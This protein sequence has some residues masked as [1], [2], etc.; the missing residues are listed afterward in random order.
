MGKQ[1]A[2]KSD[3]IYSNSPPIFTNWA[4]CQ[5][6]PGV[7]GDIG[8]IPRLVG[9]GFFQVQYTGTL[10]EVCPGES[11]VMLLNPIPP[12]PAPSTALQTFSLYTIPAGMVGNGEEWEFS[13]QV[14]AQANAGSDYVAISLNSDELSSN[15]ISPG[16]TNPFTLRTVR[17]GTITQANVSFQDGWFGFPSDR[18]IDFGLNQIVSVGIVPA[19]IGNITKM[20]NAFLRRLA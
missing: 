6:Y 1:G 16:A 17:N 3:T 7:A 2:Y 18:S 5:S 9:G 13:F 4:A 20:K 8:Y 12:V 14:G 19:A 10:W 11:V 15:V